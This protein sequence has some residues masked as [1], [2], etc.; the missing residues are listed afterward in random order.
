MVGLWEM[1][2]GVMMSTSCK[3]EDARDDWIPDQLTSL[4]SITITF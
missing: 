3:R 4:S 2:A 1:S